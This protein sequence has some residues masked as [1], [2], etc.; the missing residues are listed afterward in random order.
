[1][2][3]CGSRATDGKD[4]AIKD[5]KC[6]GDYVDG[7]GSEIVSGEIAGWGCEVGDAVSVTLP[8]GGWINGRDNVNAAADGDKYART[9][10]R[11]PGRGPCAGI[12]RGRTDE[13]V[14]SQFH[15]FLDVAVR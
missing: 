4:C 1:M 12:D 5:S 9:T 11:R 14:Q 2:L 6:E 3:R 7:S 13:C 15:V 10:H 8:N